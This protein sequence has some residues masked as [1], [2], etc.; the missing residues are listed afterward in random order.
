MEKKKEIA[1]L[2][3]NLCIVSQIKD[4][5]LDILGHNMNCPV[6]AFVGDVVACQTIFD[7]CE[8]I[9]LSA[10]TRVESGAVPNRFS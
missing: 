7:S 10:Q 2:K 5:D 1:G 3:Y 4:C 8:K 9:F 6:T